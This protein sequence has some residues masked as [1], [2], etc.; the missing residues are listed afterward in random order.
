MRPICIFEG[1]ERENHAKGYCGKHYQNFNKRGVP[2]TK[3][4]MRGGSWDNPLYQTFNNMIT[5][6]KKETNQWY[7]GRGIKVCERWAGE[8]GFKFFVEDMGPR[9]EGHQL[10]RINN[11]GDYCPENCRWVGKYQQMGNTRATKYIAGVTYS[12]KLNKFRARIKV[13]RKE[14]MF[15][16]FKTLEE[17]IAARKEGEKQYV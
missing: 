2:T 11:D 14:I 5:R 6:C 13:N 4:I 9:P 10:D 3:V 1:C 7:A 15:G 17:A 16:W 12:P 8:D